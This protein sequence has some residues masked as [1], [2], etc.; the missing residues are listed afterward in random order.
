[1]QIFASFDLDGKFVLDSGA[2]MS[3]VGVDLLQ[4]SREIYDDAG[5][6]LASHLN[7]FVSLLQMEKRTCRR[8][9]YLFP[10]CPGE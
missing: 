5:H 9:F 10:T 2:T 6:D 7:P 8:A 1:M 3:M 4:Q